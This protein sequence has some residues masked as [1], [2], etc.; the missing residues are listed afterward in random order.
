MFGLAAY[1]NQWT[2]EHNASLAQACDVCEDTYGG[3]MPAVVG[4][5]QNVLAVFALCAIALLFGYPH[6]YWRVPLLVTSLVVMI[7]GI[8]YWPCLAVGAVGFAAALKP[9][10]RPVAA[11]LS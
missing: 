11:H 5:F 1:L 7:G 3:V 6:W 2:N 10:A 9:A 4:L 8:V